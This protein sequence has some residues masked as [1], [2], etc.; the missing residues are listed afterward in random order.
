MGSWGQLHTLGSRRGECTRDIKQDAGTRVIPAKYELKYENPRSQERF[1]FASFRIFLLLLWPAHTPAASCVAIAR[2]DLDAAGCCR[3]CG[4]CRCFDH[5]A[6]GD[7]RPSLPRL[8]SP[9]PPSKLLPVPLPIGA[10]SGLSMERRYTLL[11]L[12]L[13]LL[14]PPL[15][16]PFRRPPETEPWDLGL[17]YFVRRVRRVA[18]FVSSRKRKNKTCAASRQRDPQSTNLKKSVCHSA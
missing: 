10:R 6:A 16:L 8:P 15:K 11:L 17:F 4:C 7:T 12:L 1:V 3:C 13:L 5:E 9:P 14:L 18:R 2:L